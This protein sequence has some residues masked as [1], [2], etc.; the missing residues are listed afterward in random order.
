MGET[1]G[2][3]LVGYW[4]GTAPSA[5]FAFHGP[6]QPYDGKSIRPSKNLILSLIL[7]SRLPLGLASG[8]HR[9]VSLAPCGLRLWFTIS[10][11]CV[12]EGSLS[13]PIGM[14][15]NPRLLT[16]SRNPL[17]VPAPQP[18][19]SKRVNSLSLVVFICCISS[20]VLRL[21]ILDLG[22]RR[23]GGCASLI[24]KVKL[25]PSKA[26][27]LEIKEISLGDVYLLAEDVCQGLV[28]SC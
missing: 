13:F 23:C 20:P 9:A 4:E 7:L 18:G 5:P 3:Y 11:L 6:W 24:L 14:S 28:L 19:L 15:S 10:R 16:P 25:S 12:L 27:N 2:R 8:T 21:P 22:N 17:R 1:I 26:S